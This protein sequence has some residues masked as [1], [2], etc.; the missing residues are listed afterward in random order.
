MIASPTIENSVALTRDL[1][2]V[3][4]DSNGE[5]FLELVRLTEVEIFIP[6]VNYRRQLTVPN[7]AS[8]NLFMGIP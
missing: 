1:V 5:F 7:S 2:S 6:T 8:A 4:T 3:T